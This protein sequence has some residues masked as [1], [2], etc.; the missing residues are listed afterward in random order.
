MLLCLENGQGMMFVIATAIQLESVPTNIPND[1]FIQSKKNTDHC[2]QDIF[3]IPTTP[4]SQKA[5]LFS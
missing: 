3:S 1:C 5:F 4:S 2:S